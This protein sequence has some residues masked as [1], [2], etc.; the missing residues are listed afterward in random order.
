M[1]Q[2][3]P[4][5]FENHA[6]LVPAYH[7]VAFPLFAIN[8]FFALYQVVTAFSWGNLVAFGVSVALI[9]LFFLARVMALTVQD[10]VIRL[11]ETLRMRA[12]LPADL[13]ARIGE[14]HGE[15]DRRAAVR[16]RRRTAGPGAAGARRQDPG[17]EG[18]QEDGPPVARR[19]PARLSPVHARVTRIGPARAVPGAGRQ[20]VSRRRLRESRA[21]GG[22]RCHHRAAA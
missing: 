22:R 4:Q 19:P 12:L 15:A 1:A 6:R 9:L 2:K 14:L 11:E 8:F 17:S 20:D 18:H 13:Q 7:F 10:R 21:A 3:S 16:V 5:T